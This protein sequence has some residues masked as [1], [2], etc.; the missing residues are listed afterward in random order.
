M[1]SNNAYIRSCYRR[2]CLWGRRNPIAAGSQ[3]YEGGPTPLFKSPQQKFYV[4]FTAIN[5][6]VFLVLIVTYII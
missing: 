6:L 4:A 5:L 3:P 1:D 2:F